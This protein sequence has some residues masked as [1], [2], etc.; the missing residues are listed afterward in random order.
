MTL[1]I[2][3]KHFFIALFC[4]YIVAVILLCVIRTDSM[5]EMPR[6]LFGIPMDKVVHFIMFLPFPILGYIAFHNLGIGLWREIAVLFTLIVLG[7][8]FAY[9]TERLQALTDYRS[10]EM[11]DFFSDLTGIAAGGIMV[12]AYIIRQHK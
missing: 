4:I 11:A 9:S 3:R 1:T 8:V 2:K 5:P 7:V 12:I 10:Y 6:N